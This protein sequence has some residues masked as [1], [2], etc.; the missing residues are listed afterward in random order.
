M[1]VKNANKDQKLSL[2]TLLLIRNW[3]WD[4]HQ[5]LV[6]TDLYIKIKKPCDIGNIYDIWNLDV[7]I[8]MRFLCQFKWPSYG[9]IE[10]EPAWHRCR[11]PKAPLHQIIVYEKDWKYFYPVIFARVDKVAQNLDFGNDC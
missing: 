11:H 2:V 1:C 5:R 8:Q 7:I 4:V 3:H 10:F 9:A 6:G